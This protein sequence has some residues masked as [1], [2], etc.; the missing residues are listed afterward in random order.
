MSMNKSRKATSKKSVRLAAAVA[1]GLA[2]SIA[3]AGSADAAIVKPAPTLKPPAL[4][5][6]I[7]GGPVAAR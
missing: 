4:V 7:I 1:A 2:V 3:V 5:K 6:P